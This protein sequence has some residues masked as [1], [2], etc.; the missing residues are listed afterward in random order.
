MANSPNPDY[1]PSM[2]R[3]DFGT[4]ILITNPKADRYLQRAQKSIMRG[5]DFRKKMAKN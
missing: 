4:E 2:M 3:A 5:D 1:V